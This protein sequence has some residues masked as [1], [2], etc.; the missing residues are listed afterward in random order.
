LRLSTFIK[1]FYDDDGDD[2]ADICSKVSV[3]YNEDDVAFML[4]AGDFNCG[5]G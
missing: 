4:V 2:F 3:L 5:T 1:E